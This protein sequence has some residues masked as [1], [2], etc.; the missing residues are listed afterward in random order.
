MSRKRQEQ[1]PAD[2]L[3]VIPA[4]APIETWCWVSGMSRKR[5]KRLGGR[6]IIDVRN[7]M[8][9]LHSLPDVLIRA[10]NSGNRKSQPS[11]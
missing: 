2:L 1:E 10:P 9:Y 4:F 3:C 6:T 8:R 7:G 5:T 11:D